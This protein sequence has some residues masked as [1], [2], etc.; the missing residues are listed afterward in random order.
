MK[1]RNE[2]RKSIEFLITNF[3][4]SKAILLHRLSFATCCERGLLLS[5]DVL[6][7]K[8]NGAYLSLINFM[9]EILLTKS[10]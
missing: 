3:I 6:N 4:L 1:A 7:M 2:C 9:A 5:G 10:I 8:T